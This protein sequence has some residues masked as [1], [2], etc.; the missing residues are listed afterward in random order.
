VVVSW[1]V[2]LIDG[3]SGGEG[4]FIECARVDQLDCFE[5]WAGCAGD[6]LSHQLA[7]AG[8]KELD[9]SGARLRDQ[10]PWNTPPTILGGGELNDLVGRSEGRIGR[11]DPLAEETSRQ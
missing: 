2:L 3:R 8:F 11:R 7:V 1:D 9:H 4:L 6:R 5:E 10:C